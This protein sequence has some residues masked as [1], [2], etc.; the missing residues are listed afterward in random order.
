[1]RLTSQ[2]N[3]NNGRVM[4]NKAAIFVTALALIFVALVGLNAG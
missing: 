4:I 1:M 3:N 2:K